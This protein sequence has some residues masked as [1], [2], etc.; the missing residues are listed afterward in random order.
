MACEQVGQLM[1][2]S[3]IHLVPGDIAQGGIK[4]DLVATQDGHS[5]CGPHTGIP[6]DRDQGSQRRIEPLQCFANLFLQ[7]GISL[8][9]TFGNMS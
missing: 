6:S 7:K 5:G 9:A 1:K 2:E 4:P 8:A 3:P